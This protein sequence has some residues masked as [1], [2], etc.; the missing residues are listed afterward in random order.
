M[1]FLT[2]SDKEFKHKPIAQ[3]LGGNNHGKI[4]YVGEEDP[5]DDIK[6]DKCCEKCHEGCGFTTLPCCKMCGGTCFDSSSDSEDGGYGKKI[7]GGDIKKLQKGQVPYI[8]L[9]SKEEKMIP[10]PRLKKPGQEARD[11]VFISGPEESGKSTW[12]ANFIKQYLLM[13]PHAK[14]YIFSGIDK[15]APLDA[16]KPLRIKLDEKLIEKPFKIDSFPQDSIILFDDIDTLEDDKV[17]KAVLKLRDRL[18]E[19]GRH[20]GITVISITHNP[21]AGTDTKASLLE[22][23]SMVLFPRGGDTNHLEKVLKTYMGFPQNVINKVKNL[24]SR[25]V[26][27]SKRY[28]KYVLHE[29]GCFVV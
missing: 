17:R 7:F 15:D 8:E 14:F 6:S 10:I 23:N 20:Q 2:F 9:K 27:C 4:I 1:S 28:P 13:Y 25:W 29:K 16:L 18:L 24:K 12:A 26:Q 21:M 19:K 22:S 5:D 11:N 3:V